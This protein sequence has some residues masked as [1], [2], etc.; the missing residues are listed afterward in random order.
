MTGPV[1]KFDAFF[2]SLDKEPANQPEPAATPVVAA[3]PPPAVGQAPLGPIGGKFDNFFSSL[4]DDR[5]TAA[6]AA[7]MGAVDT[8]PDSFAKVLDMSRRLGL[9]AEVVERNAPEVERKAKL[10]AAGKVLDTSPKLAGVLAEDPSIAK[11]AADDLDI[12]GVL[13]ASISAYFGGS[14]AGGVAADLARSVPA[15]GLSGLGMGLSGL[16]ELNDVASRTIERGMRAVG[17]GPIADFLNGAKLP[18][19]ANPTGV[20]KAPGETLKSAGDAVA[21]PEDRQNIGTDIAGGVGQV[22]GQIAAALVNPAAGVALMFGQGADQLADR[23]T[24]AGKAGTP[25]G[26]AAIAMGATVTAL[27]EKIGLDFLLNRVPPNIKNGIIRTLVD[28]GIGAGGE[29]LQE[30]TEGI[31]QNLTEQITVNP[32]A[33][34][35]DGVGHDAAAAGGTGAV[36]RALVNAAV[37][38]RAVH[39]RHAVAA[40]AEQ[41]VA[42]L[43][44]LVKGASS[45]KLRERAPDA[46]ARVMAAQTAGTPIETF[47][48]PADKIA[49]L[50]QDDHLS[51]D[52]DPLSQLDGF[53]EQYQEALAVGG[54]VEIS[55]ADYLT[56]IAGTDLHGKLKADV[57]ASRDGMSLR[58]AQEF[59]ANPDREAE[60]TDLVERLAIQ[61]EGEQ[62]GGAVYDDVYSQ[63][64]ASGTYTPAQARAVATLV[65]DKYTRR[66]QKFV[67]A[68]A[69]ADALYAQDGVRISGPD[70]QNRI[71]RDESDLVIARLKSGTTVQAAKTPVLD[72]VRAAGGVK[73]GSQLEQEL[74]A[75]GVN[76]KTHPGLFKR[77]GGI[78]DVDNL[79]LS[80]HDVLRDN[81]I[82]D[83]GNGYADRAGVLDALRVEAGGRGTALLTQDERDQAARLDAPV[84]S[85]RE[86]LEAAGLDPANMSHDDIKAFLNAA[87]ETVADDQGALFQGI[88]PV[89]DLDNFWKWF[90]SSAVIDEDGAPL[91]AHYLTPMGEQELDERVHPDGFLFSTGPVPDDAA[92]G[93]AIPVYLSIKNPAP[94]AAYSAALDE[95]QSV[96]E[97]VDLMKADGYDGV[98]VSETEWIAFSAGQAKSPKNRGGFDKTDPR[99]LFQVDSGPATPNALRDQAHAEIANLAR[100]IGGFSFDDE[101]AAMDEGGDLV[102]Q[103]VNEKLPELAAVFKKLVYTNDPLTEE[104]LP[105]ATRQQW[106]AS[107]P[108]PKEEA[109][110]DAKA[111]PERKGATPFNAWF[112][113]SKVVDDAGKPL[114]LFHGSSVKDIEAFR[115]GTTAYGIFFSDS[116]KSAAYYNPKADTNSPQDSDVYR[117]YLHAVKPADFRDEAVLKKIAAKAGKKAMLDEIK[118][119]MGT[120]DLYAIDSGRTQDALVRTAQEMGYDGVIMPDASGGDMANSYI[121]FEPTQIKAVNNTGAFG[122]NDPRILYD[123]SARGARGSYQ[124]ATDPD[125]NPANLIRLTQNANLSTFLH[126]SGHFFLHQEIDDVFDPRVDPA[127]LPALQAD[128]QTVLDWM[129]AK[130]DVKTATKEQ[131][132]A[133]ITRDMHEQHARGFEAYLM[134]GKAP[135]IALRRSFDQ[136]AAWLVRVYRK[137]S[138]IPEYRNK[139]TPEVRAVMDRM[140]ATDDAIADAKASAAFRVPSALRGVLTTAEQAAISKLADQ[141][142]GDA[143]RELQGR[144][145][146]ELARERA[147]WWKAERAKV[148]AS[149]ERDV[150]GRPV[151]QALNL[152]KTGKTADGSQMVDEEG[153]PRIPK[154]SRGDLVRDY[155]KDIIK[156]LPRGI[157]AKEGISHHV[158]AGMMGYSDVD[159]LR[160]ELMNV[161]PMTDVIER[162]TDDAMHE[163][164]GDMMTD[165]RI[166]ADAVELIN[167]D[168]QL[169]LI[170]LQG[171]YLRRLAGDRLGKA[172]G[173][174]AAEQGV[175][176]AADDAAA[177]REAGEDV[178][179]VGQAGA[180]AEAVAGLQV[181]GVFAEAFKSEAPAVRRAQGAAKRAVRAIQTGA[182]LAALKAVARKVISSKPVSEAT[183]DRYRQQAARIGRKAELAI[184]ERDYET[185]AT[186]KDQQLINLFLAREA[187]EAVAKVEKAQAKF[188]RLNKPDSKLSS[189]TDADFINAAREILAPFGLARGVPDFDKAAWWAR[190]QETDPAGAADLRAMVD[191]MQALL[192]GPA[193]RVRTRAIA[194]GKVVDATE[195]AWRRM[196]VA[197]FRELADTVDALLTMG[198]NA[199]TIELDGERVERKEAVAELAAQA[200]PRDSGKRVGQTEAITTTDKLALTLGG[201]SAALERAETWARRMDGGDSN[202]PFTRIFIKPVFAAVYAYRDSKTIQLRTLVDILE[203]RRKDL[204]G[205]KILA[206]ELDYKFANKGALLHAILHTGN[207]SNM[208]KLIL[209]GRGEGF[210]WGVRTQD[211]GFDRSRWDSMIARMAA[212]GTLTKEDFDTCQQIWDLMD[213][214]KG[215][216]QLAHRKMKGYYFREVEITG[217]DTPFGPYKGGYVPALADSD[218]NEDGGARTD[219]EAMGQLAN[220]GM[221]PTVEKGFTKSRTE[222]NKPL[223]LNLMKLPSHL[224]KVLKFT[225]LGPAV[226]QAARVATDRDFKAAMFGVDPK[227]IDN[228]LVPWLHRVARQTLEV[229]AATEYGRTAGKV[230]AWLRKNTG[231]QAMAGNVLNAAQ[232]ITGFST[233]LVRVK[234][235]AL[236]RGIVSSTLSPKQSAEL[237]AN[238]SAFMRGRMDSA[239]HELMTNLDGLLNDKGALGKLQESGNKHGYFLQS[240]MQNFM[241][242]AI[243]QA[244]Y[245]GAI[246]AGKTEADAVFE[247]DSA[248]RATQGSFAPEDASNFEA[249]NAFGRLFTMYF[250]FFNGQYNLARSEYDI[251]VREMGIAGAA[252]RLASLYV[253]IALIPA[254]G[255]EAIVQAARGEL[256]DDDD[257]GMLDDIAELFL[258]SQLRYFL[259][260]V[261]GVGQVGNYLLAR[262]NNKAYDDRISTSPVATSLEGAGRALFTVPDAITGDGNASRG[263]RD[264]LNAIG[265]LT[266]LPLGQLGKP[267]GY[268]ADVVQGEQSGDGIGEIARGLVTGRAEPMN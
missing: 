243:W 27:T 112:G 108:A 250:S 189:S 80:E 155:G 49:E 159:V 83:S 181:E 30:V 120:G 215:A 231:M 164:H 203:P 35:L 133:A 10:E 115:N 237:I 222:Y 171:K 124:R 100:R 165:G 122:Q 64:V 67:G 84:E 13:E 21:V 105:P 7:T 3:P 261:P 26:D 55:A 262:S 240:Y 206:P 152:L 257:D 144:V 234:P 102:E 57:R 129:G 232:Q 22:A 25:E 68:A 142:S 187:Q 110:P 130:V 95:T 90:G 54:D 180:P 24:E 193:D 244:G 254:V 87:P 201:W 216:A 42:T 219:A 1:G 52:E 214:T 169:E 36:V 185:A 140:L 220:A 88:D 170:A 227:A 56:Y 147:E 156:L 89:S 76:N 131:V 168:R 264:G 259:A 23:V 233:A 239:A 186:L 228:L 154:L 109:K 137:L 224:D 229:P 31:L 217:I 263:I 94:A 32:D 34:I 47:Y 249:Q 242:K 121:V 194:G 62:A 253:L 197:Q 212:D 78:G 218:M 230:F 207:E 198:R 111:K 104:E 43:D 238:K 53:A 191:G 167:N 17:A 157:T 209:G 61:N 28:V 81:G 200:A 48:I 138:M 177:V 268:I 225:H 210:A 213:S 161:E 2:S 173:R 196:T 175:Q 20:L 116:I 16:G 99:I 11:L 9:P 205:K 92:L 204:T 188:K 163:M 265:M 125:G 93:Q 211:G 184:A 183:P 101:M 98:R 226:Q 148:R 136:F 174:L 267:L 82:E 190:L 149:V 85:L 113:K 252:P 118:E 50:Y 158:F 247:A 79:V 151:Y 126:E 15:G 141:A 248:V 146:K 71:L 139:L 235:G 39:D 8:N 143:R 176:T 59:A 178:A 135:S 258:L 5:S 236:M 241:D 245:D 182:D 266:G 69:D 256:G 33:K 73:L 128:L 208:R 44:E 74:N 119:R 72:I 153:N 172:A 117:V 40:R 192:P 63:L 96:A 14:K 107:K 145:M 91:L 38:G 160:D 19:Y 65:R 103:T 199:R 134:E 255:A 4:K 29:A 12:L 51:Q 202:G 251:A 246:E 114:V 37:K 60:I 123:A 260:M 66:A 46:F 106:D 127:Q 6:R 58:E 223:Q 150:A 70:E 162:E 179:A 75:M 195:P 18:W 41:D 166:A 77:K 97:A 221:F 86:R 45:S 132:F